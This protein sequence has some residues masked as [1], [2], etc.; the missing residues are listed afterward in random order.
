MGREALWRDNQQSTFAHIHTSSSHSITSPWSPIPYPHCVSTGGWSGSLGQRRRGRRR[1]PATP[2]V[3][4]RSVPPPQTPRIVARRGGEPQRGAVRGGGQPD[5]AER[6]PRPQV[7]WRRHA[8]SP[9]KGGGRQGNDAPT[10][11]KSPRRPAR[12]TPWK[13]QRR[14]RAADVVREGWATPPNAG[15]PAARPPRAPPGQRREP[16]PRRPPGGREARHGGR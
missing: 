2:P 10:Q 6:P 8:V 1:A 9:A 4:P 14:R 13:G 7:R 12:C 5:G 16:R 3:P 11:T 15:G